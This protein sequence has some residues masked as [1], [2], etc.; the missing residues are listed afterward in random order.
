MDPSPRA[1]AEKLPPALMSA[2]R[3]VAADFRREECGTRIVISSSECF[4]RRLS[5]LPFSLDILGKASS[6][7]AAV[8]LSRPEAWGGAARLETDSPDVG[9]PVS[10]GR[11]KRKKY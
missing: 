4:A 1:A 2:A 3:S 10:R 7:S 8:F 6:C 11:G 5:V 9:A